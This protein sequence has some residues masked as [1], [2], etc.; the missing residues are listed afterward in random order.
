L[1]EPL[2]LSEGQTKLLEAKRLFEQAGDYFQQLS[3][4]AQ[5]TAEAVEKVKADWRAC[6]QH[7]AQI[8]DLLAVIQHQQQAAETLDQLLEADDIL[9]AVEGLGQQLTPD[10]LALVRLKA[11]AAQAEAGP[12]LAEGLAA[13]AD[14]M[15]SKAKAAQAEASAEVAEGLAAL[16]DIMESQL[17]E[18]AGC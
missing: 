7:L 10:L 9:Q 13:L 4:Q 2:A 12:E 6:Q 5:V 14:I 16:A 17:R 15:E 18:T 11:K 3:G 1:A 8:A